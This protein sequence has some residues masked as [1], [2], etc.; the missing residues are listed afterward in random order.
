MELKVKTV[1]LGTEDHLPVRMTEGASGL[2]VRAAIE[3]P[4]RILPGGHEAIPLGIAV[5]VP[6]GY[7]VQLRPRSGL[8]RKGIVCGFGT[9]DSDYRGQLYAVLFNFSGTS[10]NVFHGDRVAQIV[11]SH[12][13]MVGDAQIVDALSETK[14]GSGGMGSTGHR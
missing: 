7:E 12:V 11:V 4:V 3:A 10:H 2:D 6:A 9:V 13:V 5:E 8:T 1:E 14:R